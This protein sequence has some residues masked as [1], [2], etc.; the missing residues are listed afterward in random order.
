MSVIVRRLGDAMPPGFA[1]FAEFFASWQ[2]E[3][4]AYRKDEV[5]NDFNSIIFGGTSA[6]DQLWIMDQPEFRL[7][8]NLLPAGTTPVTAFCQIYSL[9]YRQKMLTTEISGLYT[10][11]FTLWPH[12][13]TEAFGMRSTDF[14]YKLYSPNKETVPVTVALPPLALKP[15]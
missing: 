14:E 2:N 9:K 7:L 11:K 12:V 8:H 1:D 4:W 13:S 6:S 15:S 10:I 3:F 5:K